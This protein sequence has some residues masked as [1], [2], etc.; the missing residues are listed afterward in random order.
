MQL[1]QGAVIEQYS[2][3][4]QSMM[5][6]WID[7]YFEN[8]AMAFFN[9]ANQ[10]QLKEYKIISEKLKVLQEDYKQG[11]QKIRN[12]FKQLEQKVVGSKK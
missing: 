9:K 12:D 5:L 11:L 7:D 2:G 3:S 1:Q 10:E 6:A 4:L 8:E